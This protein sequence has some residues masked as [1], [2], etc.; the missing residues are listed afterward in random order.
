MDGQSPRIEI[1]IPH[2]ELQTLELPKPATEQQLHYQIERMGEVGEDG[3]DF[4]PRQYH[5]NVERLLRPR[6]V[7]QF[8]EFTLQT[9]PVEE[10]KRVEGLILGGCGETA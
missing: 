2:P 10:Q 9:M 7:A 4:W 5:R 6:H 3:V 8:S 1:E